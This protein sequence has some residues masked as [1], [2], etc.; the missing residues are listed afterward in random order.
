MADRV[1]IDVHIAVQKMFC[2]RVIGAAEHLLNKNLPTAC[3]GEEPKNNAQQQ[4]ERH[5]PGSGGGTQ[6]KLIIF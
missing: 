4:C 5:D 6:R 3:G 2:L 1:R